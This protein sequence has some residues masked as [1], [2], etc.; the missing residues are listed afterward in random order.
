MAKHAITE[1]E[2]PAKTKSKLAKFAEAK[3]DD[4]RESLD[5]TIFGE[6][7]DFVEARTKAAKEAEKKQK[8]AAAKD[9]ISAKAAAAAAAADTPPAGTPKPERSPLRTIFGRS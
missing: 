8:H 2:L 3:D 5:E 6:I 9:D 7:D 1:A 4:I